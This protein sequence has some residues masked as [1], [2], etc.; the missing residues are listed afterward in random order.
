MNI[1]LLNSSNIQMYVVPSAKDSEVDLNFTW[2]CTKLEQKEMQFQLNFST[3]V[4]VS[5]L[6][7]RDTLFFVTK[8]EFVAKNIMLSKNIPPQISLNDT[9]NSAGVAKSIE[10]T[11]KVIGSMNF[12]MSIFLNGIMN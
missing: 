6:Y 9:S 10:S 7:P 2:K 4:D 11:M 1:S 5:P 3:P 12:F 8:D